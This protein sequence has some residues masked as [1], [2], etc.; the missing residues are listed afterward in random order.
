MQPPVSAAIILGRTNPNRRSQST[1]ANRSISRPRTSILDSPRSASYA[2]FKMA[3]FIKAA[4]AKIRAN[5]MLDY[6]CSTR[7]YNPVDKERG[8]DNWGGR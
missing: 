7:T 6:I 2:S 4:N 3:A 8:L 1:T 5:P